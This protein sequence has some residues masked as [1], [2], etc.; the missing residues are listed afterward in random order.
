MSLLTGRIYKILVFDQ[1]A[2]LHLTICKIRR[3]KATDEFIKPTNKNS[4]SNSFGIQQKSNLGGD[5]LQMK[6]LRYL[7]FEC[8]E[9]SAQAF[10]LGLAA[11]GLLALAHVIG[12]LFGGCMCICSRDEFKRSSPNKQL[13]VACLIISWYH[14]QNLISIHILLSIYARECTFELSKHL[15]WK[16]A[17]VHSLRGAFANG[18]HPLKDEFREIHLSSVL[19][20]KEF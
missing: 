18:R 12:N 7:I 1:K 5:C 13:A 16:I 11:A 3:K 4:H 9:P 15:H 19:Q 8:K 10:R 14:S 2:T 20:T 17:F 6:H